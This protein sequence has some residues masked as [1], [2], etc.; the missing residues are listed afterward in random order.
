MSKTKITN[1]FC[2]QCNIEFD[3]EQKLLAHNLSIHKITYSCSTEHCSV[4]CYQKKQLKTY[5]KTT[6]N[7]NYTFSNELRKVHFIKRISFKSGFGNSKN[8][9]VPKNTVK[10]I[11]IK[12]PKLGNQPFTVIDY[13]KKG[14]NKVNTKQN[15]NDYQTKYSKNY[16][17]NTL[18]LLDLNIDKNK[19][20]PIN[21][22]LIK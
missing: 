5:S 6:F 3:V 15:V 22:D 17:N 18:S 14:I 12:P 13:L 2:N 11:S 9:E 20:H 16:K 1:Y 7:A 4:G 10:Y 19:D 8:F 21:T